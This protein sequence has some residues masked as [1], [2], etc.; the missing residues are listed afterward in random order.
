MERTK[1]ILNEKDMPTRWYN[2][3]PDFPEP[4][5]P[6]LHPGTMEPLGDLADPGLR[7]ARNR[8]HAAFDPLWNRQRG[9]SGSTVRNLSRSTRG[10][11][12]DW[13]AKQLGIPVKKAEPGIAR[14][15]HPDARSHAV[16]REA[17]ARQR[18]LLRAVLT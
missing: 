18:K 10:D 8:A 15:F 9:V 6:E 3:L 5:P 4:L 7:V 2:V 14:V 11:A 12:Y 13:L 17:A 16:Y 1:F